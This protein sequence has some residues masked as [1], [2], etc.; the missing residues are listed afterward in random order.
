MNLQLPSSSQG[1]PGGIKPELPV[2]KAQKKESESFVDRVLD[3]VKGFFGGGAK[4]AGRVEVSLSEV[5]VTQREVEAKEKKAPA[6][7]GEEIAQA[8]PVELSLLSFEDKEF[9]EAAF[10]VDQKRAQLE[11]A[12][13]EEIAEPFRETWDT[14]FKE[15]NNEVLK[16]KSYDEIYEK[17]GEEWQQFQIGF[18]EV[19]GYVGKGLSE[20][21]I[22]DLKVKKTTSEFGT[23]LRRLS[24]RAL[25]E[26]FKDLF[27]INWEKELKE[28]TQLKDCVELIVD[29]KKA[30]DTRTK[31]TML[32]LFKEGGPLK[33]DFLDA[34]EIDHYNKEEIEAEEKAKKIE[35]AEK[36]KK[37]RYEKVLSD[38]KIQDYSD[39]EIKVART[40]VSKFW[41]AFKE[42]FG[43]KIDMQMW[44][45]IVA[46]E[47]ML[48]KAE[49][50]LFQRQYD[51]IK[52]EYQRRE[53]LAKKEMGELTPDELVDIE[54][55]GYWE[56]FKDGVS[57]FLKTMLPWNPVEG[58]ESLRAEGEK[59]MMSVVPVKEMGEMLA[60]VV[61][62][63]TGDTIADTITDYAHRVDKGGMQLSAEV[64]EGLENLKKAGQWSV[65]KNRYIVRDFTI[66]AKEGAVSRGI[67]SIMKTMVEPPERMK[68]AKMIPWLAKYAKAGAVGV[69]VA[70]TRELW[71]LRFPT[72]STLV[73][74]AGAGML[75]ERYKGE[76]KAG[77]VFGLS[78][79]AIATG[80]AIAIGGVAA[81]S[82]GW[83]P[84]LIGTAAVLFALFGV[85]VM[86]NTKVGEYIREAIANFVYSSEAAWFDTWN[87]KIERADLGRICFNRAAE[88][89][90]ARRGQMYL[91]TELGQDKRYKNL[92]DIC[93]ELKLSSQ[94]QDAFLEQVRRNPRF[95]SEPDQLK[96]LLKLIKDPAILAEFSAVN[97]L[98]EPKI[99]QLIDLYR[100]KSREILKVG[101]NGRYENLKNEF[102][103]FDPKLIAI[104]AK[105]ESDRNLVEYDDKLKAFLKNEGISVEV[106]D[107]VFSE[108]P[109]GKVSLDDA[110]RVTQAAYAVAGKVGG[111]VG[112][113]T[114]AVWN[115]GAYLGTLW[116]AEKSI[117]EIEAAEMAENLRKQSEYDR[118][119]VILALREL[120]KHKDLL[121]DEGQLKKLLVDLGFKADQVDGLY[122]IYDRRSAMVDSTGVK[123]KAI[124][125]QELMKLGIQG[126][127]LAFDIIVEAQKNGLLKSDADLPTN[128]ELEH[129][130]SNLPSDAEVLAMIKRDEQLHIPSN[131]PTKIPN[132]R[133]LMFRFGLLKRDAMGAIMD[134]DQLSAKEQETFI[135]KKVAYR[136][137][138][139]KLR[140]GLKRAELM[141][142]AVDKLIQAKKDAY[143]AKAIQ[144][145]S[146]EEKARR[147][148]G[149][150]LAILKEYGL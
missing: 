128:E 16:G 5:G 101:L 68:S 82:V 26:D 122:K 17:Y 135:E 102:Q 12:I 136:D 41:D 8:K 112:T 104:M 117:E 23:E 127:I 89:A 130:K 35:V 60:N 30:E 125:D 4:K 80:V 96:E 140:I 150:N 9:K 85:W 19:F 74:G 137:N 146:D 1:G 77:I 144:G 93:R 88:L 84:I 15:I 95:L 63:V 147:I 14:L 132:D 45:V 25:Y 108:R 59:V 114:G 99:D 141:K 7:E 28:N 37:A 20:K 31:D 106:I 131:I 10:Y 94:A 54:K 61:R 123:A 110:W 40:V 115:M 69:A 119:Q 75:V 109:P 120:V 56:T 76:I 47:P 46:R 103:Q 126:D 55:L 27:A 65:D 44:R 86:Y 148:A 79:A 70:V 78:G 51:N 149:R 53:L 100:V 129:I 139:D 107:K 18:E 124:A 58:P 38:A 67:K 33:V 49:L 134:L 24:D 2:R 116:S 111:A 13:Y 6:M 50:L 121:A 87:E 81:L 90:E 73:M 138:F 143:V 42:R 48:A 91:R 57:L 32:R 3:W 62:P 105:L 52:I 72:V 98:K 29:T 97:D 133:A 66:D 43:G 21:E 34:S 113:V 83:V 118:V 36:A 145:M 92:E 71:N 142:S 22:A 39:E 64:T 11:K